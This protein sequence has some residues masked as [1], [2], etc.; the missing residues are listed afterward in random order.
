VSDFYQRRG[1]AP[2]PGEGNGQRFSIGLPAKLEP[3][4]FFARIES[5]L[6]P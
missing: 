2:L 1:F 4:G 5:E 3:P 6:V